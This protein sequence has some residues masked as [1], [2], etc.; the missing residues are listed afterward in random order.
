MPE[1]PEPRDANF[2]G[3]AQPRPGSSMQMAWAALAPVAAIYG[4]ALVENLAS[5]NADGFA[6][7]AGKLR[8]RMRRSSR[9]ACVTLDFDG[10]AAT[11]LLT[12]GLPDEARLA[13]LDLD[14]TAAEVQGQLLAWSPELQQWIPDSGVQLAEE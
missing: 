6:S 3:Q 9:G 2:D 10:E 7:I 11:I 14:V 8:K 13:L 4:A 1:R 5:R 12:A